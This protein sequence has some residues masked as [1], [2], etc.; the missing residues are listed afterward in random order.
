MHTLSRLAFARRGRCVYRGISAKT[1]REAPI[2][3]LRSFPLSF[4][5]GDSIVIAVITRDEARSGDPMLALLVTHS[6]LPP[7]ASRNNGASEAATTNITSYLK[8][9]AAISFPPL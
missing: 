2:V 4:K 7:S 9:G 5:K 8:P 6:P 3:T 1:R